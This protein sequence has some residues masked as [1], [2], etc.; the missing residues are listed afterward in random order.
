[1]TQIQKANAAPISSEV[2]I[3]RELFAP[4][5][6]QMNDIEVEYRSIPL[7]IIARIEM[8]APMRDDLVSEFVKY[9]GSFEPMGE[10]RMRAIMED[11]WGVG[12]SDYGAV[13]SC[14]MD[15]QSQLL[16]QDEDELS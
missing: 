3:D 5:I 13:L 7:G 6:K 9:G 16:F 11:C 14:L 4:L 2:K 15:A 10:G 1:M 8:T 12:T